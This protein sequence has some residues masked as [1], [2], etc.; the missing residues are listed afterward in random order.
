MGMQMENA[1]KGKGKTK[2]K[3]E[4]KEKDSDSHHHS[5]SSLASISSPWRS[6]YITM[7]V[8]VYAHS[9]DSLLP[10]PAQ[11]AVHCVV[12]V[13]DDT[14]LADEEE[15]SKR[16]YWMAVLLPECWH[17]S[18]LKIVLAAA[19]CAKHMPQDTEVEI[20][21][22]EDLLFKQLACKVRAVDPDFLMGYEVQNSSFGYLVDRSKALNLELNLCVE[23]GR[24]P[25]EKPFDKN[26]IDDGWAADHES[27]I[28]VS[29]RIVINLWRR[30]RSELKLF[31]YTA[32]NVALH[33]L[34]RNVPSFSQE[35]LRD[36][37]SSFSDMHRTLRH[38]FRMATLNLDLLH[39]QDLIRRTSESSRLYGIDFFSTLT[40]GSQYRVEAAMLKTAHPAGF[41]VLSPTKKAVAGMDPIVHIP[42]VMEPISHFYHNPIVVLDFQSLYP[43][44][45]IAYNLCFSTL[46]GRLRAGT[47]D[48][49]DGQATVQSMGV[50]RP[51]PEELSAIHSHEGEGKSFIAPNGA[52]FCPRSTREGVLPK[53][54]REM[55]ETR[56]LVKREMKGCASAHD[57]PS[58][59]VLHR[60][61]DAQQFAIKM[62]S[63][64][65][66]GYCAASFSGRMPCVDLADAIVSCGRAT[67][68]WAMKVVKEDA[69]KRWGP[70]QICYG[71]TDSM[72]IELKG[73]SKEEAFRIGKDIAA[74]IT[75]MSPKDVVL[76]FEKV[77]M[78]SILSRKKHYCGEMFE[79]ESDD[80]VFEGKGVETARRDQCLATVK[81]QERALRILFNS[82]DLTLVRRYVETQWSR[83]IRGKVPLKDFI[84]SKEVTLGKYHRGSEPPGALVAMKAQE[85]DSRDV[86]PQRWRVPYVAV[87]RSP[88][89]PV[90]DL[91]VAPHEV[92]M[93][94]R[95]L[96][97]NT[98][99]YIEKQVNPALMRLLSLAGADVNQWY[100][101]W[102]RPAIPLQKVIYPTMT[103]GVSPHGGTTSSNISKGRGGGLAAP[104]AK[105]QTT[106][107]IFVKSGSCQ[108]C[109]T[110]VV[111][112]R[113]SNLCEACKQDKM[114]SV[115]SLTARLH[116]AQEDEQVHAQH[117]RGCC[118]FDQHSGFMQRNA[119]IGES[120][121]S[122]IHCKFFYDRHHAVVT[123]DQL[124]SA[125]RSLY[126]GE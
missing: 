91:A 13:I 34:H 10:D 40:R 3:G 88:G 79:K 100:N 50:L 90:R 106:M 116:E 23:L 42:L 119:M 83:M 69:D 113:L 25:F 64:V 11:D 21:H 47:D 126:D 9:R 125:M 105:Q 78:G 108:V 121:C 120:A 86:A 35:Q 68:E 26:A 93:R 66:Y 45:M 118:G 102:P 57:S 94:G 99:Y 111:V 61:L 49:G 17:E 96:I 97:L 85:A 18:Q 75:A 122:S 72:F 76:K 117:C 24:L 67:L 2:R 14:M 43:S 39:K 41:V 52:M 20:V 12:A 98:K 112:E 114:G 63:N 48:L 44:V 74:T 60:V 71:D 6:R 59:V 109:G 27:G 28:F 37:Y 84:F 55:L 22:K 38:I 31:N 56:Q 80:G 110:G 1:R 103:M 104:A 115:L 101:E 8:E 32:H 73:R 54:L 36:W 16:H 107:D 30:M 4:R 33:L 15:V 77:Y 123:I 65:T 82:R 51:Y 7:S 62:L 89:A 46:L 19:M 53:M 81:I 87:W 124:E 58:Q 5:G 95:D 92:L 29:G 70:L